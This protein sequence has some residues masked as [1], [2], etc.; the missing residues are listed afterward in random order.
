MCDL[1]LLLDQI[2]LLLDNRVVLVLVLAH[3]EEHLDHVLRTTVDISLVENVSELVENGMGDGRGH[4]LQEQADLPHEADSDLDTVVGRL[5]KQQ[6]Q[7][8]GSSHLVGNLVVDKMGNEHGRR[9]ANCLVVSLE[10]LAETQDEPLDKQ[11]ADLGQLGVANRSQ[12]SIDGREG[13]TGMLGLQQ[14]LAK[15]TAATDEVLAKEFGDYKLD[16]GSV[17]LVDQT[18]DRLLQCLPS[19]TLVFSGLFVGDGGL[20]GTKPVR[21]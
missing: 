8:L 6:Q 12:A 4:L 10:R 2:Q 14:T 17:N 11:F 13:Q 16:V 7:N 9:E 20:E 1:I 21:R 15:Q 3:L 5:R 18:V 19:H